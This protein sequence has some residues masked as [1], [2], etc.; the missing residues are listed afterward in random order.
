MLKTLLIFSSLFWCGWIHA[1]NVV[2]TVYADG[3]LIEGEVGFSNG[4]LASPGTPVLVLDA[5][6]QPLGETQIAED[7]L[8]QYRADTV[9]T[10][11]FKVDL[12]AGHVAE[13]TL[14]AQ[15]L[16]DDGSISS[17]PAAITPPSDQVNTAASVTLDAASAA[18][19]SELVRQAVAKQVRPLQKELAAYKE[20]VMFRDI[21]GGIG[22]IFGLFGT[23][24]WAS[25]RRRA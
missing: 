22:F 7:G 2:S 13:M 18:A 25:A 12:S 14:E 8:F 17:A 11:V 20:K 3:M 24:A 1:H 6:G 19:L 23:A 16:S 5:S 9:Q 4:D 10:Y 15:E 21:L